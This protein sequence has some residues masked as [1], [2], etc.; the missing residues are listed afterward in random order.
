[1]LDGMM[2]DGVVKYFDYIAGEDGARL[3]NA[4][5]ETS[6][7]PRTRAWQSFFVVNRSLNASAIDVQ[8]AARLAEL[9]DFDDRLTGAQTLAAAKLATVK[10]ADGEV[11]AHGTG[12][13]REALTLDFFER[14][15]GYQQQ[16]LVWPAMV[17]AVALDVAQDPLHRDFG[18]QNRVLG[19]A[20]SRDIEL[21]NTA[22]HTVILASS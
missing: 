17:L 11:F 20:A 12:V 5:I 6:Q 13:D 21:E 22:S 16:S 4:A 2:L 9:G 18:L 10:P 19:H 15:L 7:A 8:M 1:M 3:R 14:F